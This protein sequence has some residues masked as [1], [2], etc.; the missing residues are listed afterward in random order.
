VTRSVGRCAA[1]RCSVARERRSLE[2]H[3]SY[4]PPESASPSWLHFPQIHG[5]IST[6][7]IQRFDPVWQPQPML[8]LSNK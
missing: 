7:L 8:L 3:S 2:G 6:L 4:F 5:I 1:G